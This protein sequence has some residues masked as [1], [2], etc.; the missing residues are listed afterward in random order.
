M[1]GAGLGFEDPGEQQGEPAEQDVGA[2]TVLEPVMDLTQVQ[3]LPSR[4][5]AARQQEPS[6]L[7]E[8]P[9]VLL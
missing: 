6:E 2:D 1:P 4:P 3:H 8:P 5:S 7:V 9:R